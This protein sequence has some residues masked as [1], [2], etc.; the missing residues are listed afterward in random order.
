MS[1]NLKRHRVPQDQDYTPEK[2][3]P[4]KKDK[5]EKKESHS[6]KHHRK[7]DKKAKEKKKKKQSRPPSGI[8]SQDFDDIGLVDAAFETYQ[9]KP[10]PI[11]EEVLNQFE[12]NYLAKFVQEQVNKESRLFPQEKVEFAEENYK[13]LCHLYE[14]VKSHGG[15]REVIAEQKWS[16]VAS[17]V[18]WP[19]HILKPNSQAKISAQKYDLKLKKKAR[20]TYEQYL[21]HYEKTVNPDT[22]LKLTEKKD[23]VK[24]EDIEPS[25]LKE[26]PV[27]EIFQRED[28]TPEVLQ[29]IFAE[30]VVIIRNC[31]NAF[32]I[33]KNLFAPKLLAKSHGDAMVDV[34][35]QDPES[36]I[37]EMNAR[38][39]QYKRQIKL[40]D[41]VEYQSKFEKRAKRVEN[42]A[43]EKAEKTKDKN[44][45][46]AS[47]LSD[48]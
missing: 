32:D 48:S 18:T 29:D 28:L 8:Y 35:N 23:G 41:F 19:H 2:R 4:S 6:Q 34:V 25:L 33:K 47:D 1:R 22:I 3:K 31:Q 21:Y 30:E 10:S 24:L 5:V 39:R 13:F 14:T 43:A 44:S 15:F 42:E 16:I 40:K 37:M 38:N 27:Y 36:T 11:K 26:V 12:L 9:R 17:K 46:P 20:E 45:Q 7:R